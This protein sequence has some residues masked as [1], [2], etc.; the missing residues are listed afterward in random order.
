LE[1]H[2]LRDL[3]ST[4]GKMNVDQASVKAEEGGKKDKVSKD[5]RKWHDDL[6][7]PIKQADFERWQ[8]IDTEDQT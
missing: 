7:L 1:P 5:W 6:N 8:Q 3:F 4:G 2:G